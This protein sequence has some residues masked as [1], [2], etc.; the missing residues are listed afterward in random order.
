[1]NLYR[2]QIKKGGSAGEDI[3]HN[4]SLER[5]YEFP[6]LRSIYCLQKILTLSAVLHFHRQNTLSRILRKIAKLTK[7]LS[8]TLLLK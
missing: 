2:K 5:I 4:V 1:M 6:C 7:S 3:T 8:C